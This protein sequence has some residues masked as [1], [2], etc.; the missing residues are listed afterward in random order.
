MLELSLP[1]HAA[2][3]AAHGDHSDL[4]GDE[5]LNKIVREVLDSIAEKHST[6]ASYMDD[7]RKD[8]DEARAFAQAKNLLTLPEGWQ[9]AG[10]SDAGVRARHLRCRRIQSGARARTATGRILLDHADPAGLAE[11]ARG[12]ETPRIQFLQP[13]APGDS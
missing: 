12:I 1:L 6:P 2:M 7:A 8:L 9:S 10:D 13:E 3:F 5:R 4:K 11:G